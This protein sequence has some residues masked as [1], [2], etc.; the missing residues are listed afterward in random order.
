LFNVPYNSFKI[1]FLY[2][3]SL[4]VSLNLDQFFT[5]CRENKTYKNNNVAKRENKAGKTI[6]IDCWR[7]V[8]LI[9]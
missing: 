8:A 9:Y 6:F 3:K 5:I 2:K 4:Q 7:M 1:L